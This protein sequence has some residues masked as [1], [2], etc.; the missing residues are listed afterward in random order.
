MGPC[1]RQIHFNV[2]ILL[3]FSANALIC[4]YFIL[5]VQ[6]SQDQVDRSL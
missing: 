1:A 5:L 3:L 6:N 2:N 4:I